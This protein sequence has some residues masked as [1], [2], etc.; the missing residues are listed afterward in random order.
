MSCTCYFCNPTRKSRPETPPKCQLTPKEKILRQQKARLMEAEENSKPDPENDARHAAHR[1]RIL[2]KR[3]A[4]AEAEQ[5]ESTQ[6][7]AMLA[8]TLAAGL[9]AASS[10][11]AASEDQAEA[12]EKEDKICPNCHK[13]NDCGEKI[14]F[15][16]IEAREGGMELIAYV[17]FKRKSNSGVTISVG[18]DL[19]A[20]NK[21]DLKRLNLNDDLIKKLE[22]YLGM[23]KLVAD[24]Y[25]KKHP[26]SITQE[27]GELIYIN[28][29]T[30]ATKRLIDKYN[31]DSNVKFNCIPSQAQTVIASVEY[32]YGSAKKGTK[33]FWRQVT[34]QSWQEA[35]DNLM[36]FQDDYAPRRI[37]EA[38]LLKEIL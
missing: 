34:E 24:E 35:Y 37:L 19:G 15:E 25:L 27:Q 6:Q 17:P 7:Q 31:A 26:L 9:A 33:N 8:P 3:R 16:F 23:K 36:N 14:D 32:Q 4:A 29:K 2:A 10:A 1:E 12:K 38:K 20:R 18:F 13:N 21:N 28:N 30:Q 11:V 5:A 22:P